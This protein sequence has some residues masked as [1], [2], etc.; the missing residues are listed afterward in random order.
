MGTLLEVPEGFC[1][2]RKAHTRCMPLVPLRDMLQGVGRRQGTVLP[3]LQS[4]L[5]VGSFSVAGALSPLPCIP[6]VPLGDVQG[7]GDSCATAASIP[8]LGLYS[9]GRFLGIGNHTWR[10]CPP[11][12]AP[13]FAE[14]PK[15]V[16][17]NPGGQKPGPGKLSPFM[18]TAPQALMS[19]V[20]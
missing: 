11:T 6:L 19:C 5:D 7:L 12:Q 4:C 13:W 20:A 15:K 16:L 18:F 8:E 3:W 1:H 9:R 10:S 17:Q 14:R 2:G